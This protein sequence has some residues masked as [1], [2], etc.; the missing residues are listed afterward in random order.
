MEKQKNKGGRP[1]KATPSVTMKPY[2]LLCD[3]EG[4]IAIEKAAERSGMSKQEWSRET[5]LTAARNV[6][7][8]KQEVATP[9]DNVNLI[10]VVS[11]MIE[12][13]NGP[14]LK[15]IDELIEEGKK[16]LLKRLLWK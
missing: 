16:P 7:I 15:K 2:T 5:L 13:S 12:E 1:K 14:L 10:D 8:G 6:L 4:M 11:K 3:V 9:K